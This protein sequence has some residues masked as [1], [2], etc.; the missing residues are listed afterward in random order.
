MGSLFKPARSDKYHFFYN[1]E[2]GRRRK[3]VLVSDKAVSRRLANEIENQVALRKAGLIDP[4]A[5]RFRDHEARAL[6]EHLDDFRRALTAKGDSDDYVD[7]TASRIAKL[8]DLAKV[9][10]ISDLSTSAVLDA[11][12]MLRDANFS[13]ES[14]NHYIRAVKGF[15]RWLKKDGRARA[16]SGWYIHVSR[17]SGQAARPG[18]R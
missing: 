18:A 1:D 3:K 15:S 14:C 2:N 12:Q 11:V 8:F 5:E 6:T 13:G 4:K 17:R 7:Q 16:R 9:K 10:R